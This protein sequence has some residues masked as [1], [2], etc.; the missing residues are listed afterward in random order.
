MHAIENSSRIGFSSTKTFFS[1]SCRILRCLQRSKKW[2]SRFFGP[3]SHQKSVDWMKRRLKSDWSH[4]RIRE[5]ENT[6]QWKGKIVFCC[7]QKNDLDFRLN[8]A[9][10]K[11]KRD[12]KL[13]FA[14]RWEHKKVCLTKEMNLLQKKKSFSFLFFISIKPIFLLYLYPL[15]T[16]VCLHALYIIQQ[17][18]LLPRRE[19]LGA[20]PT[21]R[22]PLA[23]DGH[24]LDR[25]VDEEPRGRVEVARP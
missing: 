10:V 19:S 6:L 15:F 8:N 4:T 14:S 16:A 1:I 11:K 22:N 3:S 18:A 13:T 17:A 5:D 7:R 12:T 2:V 21:Q 9:K 20:E 25:S 24:R 23:R